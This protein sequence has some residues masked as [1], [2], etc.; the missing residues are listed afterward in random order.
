MKKRKLGRHGPMV[1]AVGLGCMGMS[2]SR[3]SIDEKEAIATLHRAFE[4]GV[5]FLDTADVYGAG[6]NE[7]LIGKVLRG[8]RD[9]L[10]IATKCGLTIEPDKVW[11]WGRNGRPEHVKASVEGSLKRLGI[12]VIDLY[13]LHR[14]DRNV[15]LEDTMGAFADLQKA[16]KIRYVG[17]SGSDADE[18]ARAHK[19]VPITALQNEYSLFNRALEGPILDTCRNL[20]IG[21]VPYA[22]L[23]RAFLTGAL[24]APHTDALD[25]RS[26]HPAHKG[27]NFEKNQ[28]LVTK[29][30]AIA[31]RKG[32]TGGQLAL[33]WVLAQGED[34]VPIPG[35]KRRSYLE[36]NCKA[37]DVF[38]SAADL[39]E[40]EALD[41]ARQFA[42]S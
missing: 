27:S 6:L 37:T 18:I 36:E 1:G 13:Y 38:L 4:L 2:G 8:R 31:A 7:E 16:G 22:P 28:A 35:T 33:A 41:L 3:G 12:D 10:V 29:F 23:G 11:S 26:V 5:D 42:V 25:S 17:L 34:M 32:V 14:S 19:V 20:G 40:I 39:A 24:A 9:S 30:T 21:I 15:P